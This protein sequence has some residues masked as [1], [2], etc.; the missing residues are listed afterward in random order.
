MA[1]YSY[2]SILSL[3]N[4]SVKLSILSMQACIPMSL[5]WLNVILFPKEIRISPGV[6]IDRKQHE[7]NNSSHH[8]FIRRQIWSSIWNKHTKILK[9]LKQ[10]LILITYGYIFEKR[11][12]L[13]PLDNL[14]QPVV[15]YTAQ[16]G[17]KIWIGV[18]A[19]RQ[20]GSGK[21]R[22]FWYTVHRTARVFFVKMSLVA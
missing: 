20:S 6:A 1:T 13:A 21:Q 16:I 17:K 8:E 11:E 12:T 19:A 9:S 18:R 5:A 3:R 7:N 15:R 22:M 2:W 14:K 4:C 10:T